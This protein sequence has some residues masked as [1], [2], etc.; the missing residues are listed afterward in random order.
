MV[1]QAGRTVH[2]PLI[3]TFETETAYSRLNICQ[4]METMLNKETCLKEELLNDLQQGSTVLTANSRL[5]RHLQKWFSED[6]LANDHT[7]WPSPEIYSLNQW[8][9]NTWETLSL[10]SEAISHFLL[11]EEHQEL[12]LWQDLLA[13]EEDE[14]LN[15]AN[16]AKS[17]R[18]A[19]MLRCQWL[20]DENSAFSEYNEDSRFFEHLLGQFRQACDQL[21]TMPRDEILLELA[22]ITLPE[23]RFG[24]KSLIL[25]GFDEIN[26]AQDKL[27]RHFQDHGYRIS[28]KEIRQQKGHGSIMACEDNREECRQIATWLKAQLEKDPAASLAVIVPELASYR[29][30]IVDALDRHLHALSS[31]PCQNP[32]TKS[33]NIS[34]APSLA[35]QPLVDCALKILELLRGKIHW[36]DVRELLLSPFLHGWQEE[37]G[38]RALLDEQLRKSG[39]FHY[40][41]K[42]I[43]YTASAH[44]K[45]PWYCPA[46]TRQLKAIADIECHPGQ[47]K[48]YSEWTEI[49][50]KTLAEAGWA[51][52]RTLDSE[53]YQARESWL[54]L[55]S[56][57]TSLGTFSGKT[58]LPSTLAAL[59]ML[60]GNSP[61]QAQTPE[62]PIQVLGLYE[63]TGLTFDAI[64]VAGLDDMHW[65]LRINANPF[66]PL[67]LQRKLNMPGSSQNRDLELASRHLERLAEA[68]REIIFSYPLHEGDQALR[69]SHMLWQYGFEKAGRI[70]QQK[71]DDIIGRIRSS[72]NLEN[73]KDDTAQEISGAVTGGARRLKLQAACPFQAFAE[74][75]LNARALPAASPGLDPMERGNLLHHLLEVFWQHTTSQA[76]L[77]AMN[78]E[79][80]DALVDQCINDVLSHLQFR[81]GRQFRQLESLRLKELMQ[82]WLVL[83]KQ[84]PS[85]SVTAVEEIA[86]IELSGIRLKL[87][88]D[89][90]DT[91]ADGR[92]ILI[93]YKTGKCSVQQW[94]GE[95]PD[96][97]QLPLYALEEKPDALAF[98]QLKTGDL[99]F[100]GLGSDSSMLTG[101]A[102]SY[103]IEGDEHPDWPGL[104]EYWQQ[105]LQTLAMACQQGDA[106]V[107][108]KNRQQTCLYCHFTALCRINETENLAQ[109]VE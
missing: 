104:I 58:R 20:L 14:L 90:I 26:P 71:T 44:A 91:L 78:A 38:R 86:H 13:E 42:D 106:A 21:N 9:E 96:E 51:R 17:M 5:S 94:F 43:I 12:K 19:R 10:T 80:L 59:K 53:E 52:G 109:G 77:L 105:Q 87:K 32:E 81:I 4:T 63:A 49:F 50:H 7:A 97:P 46:L 48:A 74:F 55:L 83:E 11:M 34:L 85:F 75:R 67:P 68:S 2:C 93:D 56:K 84:R 60:A 16:T 40:T 6:Q 37:F 36:Q 25:T 100:T 72:Q 95:Q 89:R 35:E 27:F 66:I 73:F 8:L 101:L 65:P 64:W 69:P 47:V 92:K 45:A 33:Y 103:S 88:I 62:T 24:N 30:L 1:N 99:K 107:R 22:K 57:L 28:W 3:S 31:M 108:P 39:K 18:Q 98:A 54:N 61:F 79:E 15:S 41:L 23:N 102:D 29:P 82:K 76:K 70:N